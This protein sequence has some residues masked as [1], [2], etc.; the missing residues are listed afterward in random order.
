MEVFSEP[1]DQ[2][3]PDTFGG[4]SAILLTSTSP[5]SG[6]EWSHLSAVSPAT[7]ASDRNDLPES[8]MN[9]DDDE[10]EEECDEEDP[11]FHDWTTTL[12]SHKLALFIVTL[13]AHKDLRLTSSLLRLYR[14]SN[15][16]TWCQPEKRMDRRTVQ[17]IGKGSHPKWEHSR[18]M[19]AR[20]DFNI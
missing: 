10:E 15:S 12:V 7:A 11:I 1:S 4:S 3:Q 17:W 9:D 14:T 20:K 19:S 18:P 5:N 13:Q 2:P 8:P 16:R 6:P